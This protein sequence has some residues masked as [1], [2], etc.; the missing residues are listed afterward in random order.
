VLLISTGLSVTFVQM[1]DFL[2]WVCLHECH[3]YEISHDRDRCAFDAC[4]PSLTL[5]REHFSSP[6]CNYSSFLYI[7]AYL[8]VRF[9]KLFLTEEGESIN[10]NASTQN[11]IK[12]AILIGALS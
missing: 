12:C 6:T 1:T 5:T 4:S 2:M 10:D 11:V 8:T 7:P 9:A 3:P